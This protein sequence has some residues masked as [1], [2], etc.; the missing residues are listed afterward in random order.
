[1]NIVPT[2]AEILSRDRLLLKG[3]IKK[4]SERW[5]K[6]KRTTGE[7]TNKDVKT[8][9][10]SP[11]AQSPPYNTGLYPLVTGT[12]DIKGEVEVNAENKGECFWD[13]HKGG[14]SSAALNHYRAP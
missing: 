6:E 8:E 14:Q 1:M 13:R 7:I 9:P 3:E 10:L 12:V 11:K 5:R 2:A 4:I